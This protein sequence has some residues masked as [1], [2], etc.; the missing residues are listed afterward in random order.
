MQ[1]ICIFLQVQCKHEWNTKTYNTNIGIVTM[2][3]MELD[4]H[5][6]FIA[7]AI[8]TRIIRSEYT[9]IEIWAAVESI[10]YLYHVHTIFH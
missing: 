5:D 1:C 3:K 4:A 10:I 6:L 2:I 7:M 9:P 8:M